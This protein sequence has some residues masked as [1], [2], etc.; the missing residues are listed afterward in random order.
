MTTCNTETCEN[1]AV[2]LDQFQEPIC[3]ECRDTAVRFGESPD[4]FT[5]MG[6]CSP[7][8]I[9]G[10]VGNTLKIISDHFGELGDKQPAPL[11]K[12]DPGQE[13]IDDVNSCDLGAS[14]LTIFE[15]TL[16]EVGLQAIST[17]AELLPEIAKNKKDYDA[18]YEFSTRMKR[19][20]VAVR[21][22]EKALQSDLKS[23]YQT[24]RA[25]IQKD[26]E[27]VLGVI[28]PLIA[29]SMKAREYIE[30]ETEAHK[31]NKAREAAAAQMAEQARIQAERERLQ[32]EE[33]ARQE[34]ERQRQAEAAEA[35][36]KE[37]ARLAAEREK[38]ER[39]RYEFECSKTR[40][41]FDEAWEDGKINFS[42]WVTPEGLDRVIGD[43]AQEV[44][45]TP[46]PD[47]DVETLKEF[48]KSDSE[49][50]ST[51]TF[52]DITPSH[53]FA[54]PEKYSADIKKSD[55]PELA[56]ATDIPWHH[57]NADPVGDIKKAFGDNSPLLPDHLRGPHP[58]T[59][60]ANQISEF[61][62]VSLDTLED[63]QRQGFESQKMTDALYKLIERVRFEVDVFGQAVAAEPAPAHEAPE[64]SPCP[65][66]KNPWPDDDESCPSCGTNIPF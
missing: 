27:F 39:E 56:K 11:P 32:R 33:E 52:A 48:F 12:I 38:L 28:D 23:A 15:E 47:A 24:D 31:E 55:Y 4:N 25:K 18:V 7:D 54:D 53:T 57:K 59:T 37:E 10:Q 20:S 3:I 49:P 21:K 29:S 44:I 16:T 13:M 41:D 65:S 66:C 6:A 22:K 8:E 42:K 62:R 26:L 9:K 35:H 1:Q 60:H 50:S 14:K 30:A 51:D 19:L 63:H 64:A 46:M 40:L 34:Q 36:R 61:M 45:Q 43:A 17:E 2:Y 58:D 5:H